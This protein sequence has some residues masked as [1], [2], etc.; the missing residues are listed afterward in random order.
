MRHPALNSDGTRMAFSYQGDIWVSDADGSDPRRLTVHEAYES[1]PR[2]SPDDEEIAFSGSRYGNE[3]V[4][5]IH[6]GGS[7]ARRLTFHSSDDKVTDWSASHG[8]IFGTV[9]NYKQVEWNDE[10][11]TVPV[12]GGTPSRL[13]DAFGQHATA[14]PNGKLIAFERGVCRIAREAYRGSANRDIWIFNTQTGEF[15]QLTDD[16]G[17]DFMPRWQNDGTLYWISARTGAYNI[18]KMSVSDDGSEGSDIGQISNFEETGCTYFDVANNGRLICE[19]L[20]SFYSGM[21][22]ESLQELGFKLPVDYRFDPEEFK[23][24]SGNL[25]DYEVSPNGKWIAMEIRGEI[26]V[27]RNDKEKKES[28]N[29]SNHPYRDMEPTWLN[30]STLI[31]TSDRS[32]SYELYLAR[33]TDPK[34][35]NLF[36][37]LKREIVKLTD[38]EEDERHPLMSPD[39][40]K[41]AYHQGRGKLIVADI[42]EKG[43]MTNSRTLVDSWAQPRGFSWSPDSKWL[44]YSQSDLDFNHEIYIHKADDSAGPINVSMHPR[45]DYAPVWGADGKKILFV[46]ERARSGNDVWYA[47]L[48]E[49]EWEKTEED[50]EE[51][52]YFEPEEP[53]DEE[54]EEDGDDKK[55]KKKE[56]DVEPIEIDTLNIHRRLVQLTSLPG[57]EGNIA[58]DDK[59]E[60]VYFTAVNT[61]KDR[62]DLY[63]IKFDGEEIQQVTSSGKGPSDVRLGPKGKK[64]YYEESGRLNALTIKN[65][66]SENL[67]HRAEMKID[68][69][70]ERNQVFEEAWS[71][72]EVNFYDPQFH[73]RDWQALK[74]EYKPLAMRASTSQD[75]RFV[76]N[77]MLG[78]LNASHMGLYGSDPEKTQS[79]RTGLIGAE[80]KPVDDGVEVTLVI[81]D[82]PAD[83]E[84]TRLQVGDVIT[85]VDGRQITDSVNFY[86]MLVNSSSDLVLLDVKGEDGSMREVAIR[87]T[88]GLRNEKYRHWVENKRK[89][90]EEYSNG[91]LG[92]IHVEGMNWPSFERFERELTASASGKDALVIDVRFN[93]GGWTTDYLLTVLNVRQHA[94]TIPRGAA[95]SLEQHDRFSDHYPYGER[96]PYAAWTKPAVTLCN[97]RSYSNAEIFSHAFKTLDHGPLV[98][99]PTFGA[100]ISTG[101]YRLLDGS[102]VRMPFRAWYVKATGQNM[103]RVPAVPDILVDNAPN[104]RALEQ[105]AQ[106]KRAVEEMMED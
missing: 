10:V 13:L 18:H 25:D 57:N 61:L 16:D 37:T 81:M 30:D 101:G 79:Q 54:D 36:T 69:S 39:G 4:Y 83:K 38:T 72:L 60:F 84:K 52:W 44:A 90:V 74:E 91:R 14:S 99:Q 71:E 96:L 5:T 70:R 11:H 80:V 42:D 24:Y 88:T 95:D 58:T 8:I 35:T 63:K 104:S 103:E 73:G 55:D 22:G 64:I 29:I 27:K 102:F 31:F 66:K 89:L 59:G 62:S 47:W 41:I 3:D 65:D 93:G 46:S 32:G 26:F 2:W 106:L 12:K 77:R 17:N 76:F 98:G 15:H 50:R 86:Q 7:T 48:T 78:R 53:E 28:V 33:S 45:S 43:E 34:K 67:P 49:E 23:S 68:H 51:G 20:G 105:D 82:S 6:A 97:A 21:S 92:Y 56:K 9:R 75:F 100:V 85:S 87:P 94:Y 1:D 40:K 19:R